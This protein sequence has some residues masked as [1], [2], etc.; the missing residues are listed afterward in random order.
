MNL[1]TI[2]TTGS[3]DSVE[4]YFSISICPSNNHLFTIEG[5]TTEDMMEIKSL[6][7]ILLEDYNERNSK[8]EN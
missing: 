1:K 3:Y 6:I 5:L 8:G 7:D 2:Q 4:D